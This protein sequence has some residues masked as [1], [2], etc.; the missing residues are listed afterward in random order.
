MP[1]HVQL[2]KFFTSIYD[3]IFRIKRAEKITNLWKTS[4]LLILASA[5]IYGWM[6]Y[7]GI[8]STFL[9]SSMAYLSSGEYETSKLWF[10]LGR[11]VYGAS[12]AAAV[13]FVPSMIY[14]LITGIPYQKLIIMQQIVLSVLLLER[15][16]WIPIAI[17][18]GLD[19]Y[20]SPLSF[21]VIASYIFEIEWF[22][23]F[24]GAITLFQ[25]WTIWFQ[26]R[27]LHAMSEN[28]KRTIWIFIILLHL[29]GWVLA[30]TISFTDSYMISRWFE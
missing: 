13:L 18:I 6:A 23:Y 26:F 30:A 14:Q 9:S 27:F 16:I 29:L 17:F 24:F 5:L 21:G 7:L 28:E 1:Y 8:G 4:L 20:V 10:L 3:H 25:L 12:F 2:F 11:V 15:L 22:I 19:W